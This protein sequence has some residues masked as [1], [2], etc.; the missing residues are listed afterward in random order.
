MF[1]LL[2]EIY[3]VW[4]FFHLGELDFEELFYFMMLS[5]FRVC[6]PACMCLYVSASADSYVCACMWKTD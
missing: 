5:F 4:F 1:N 3:S 2:F 6:V